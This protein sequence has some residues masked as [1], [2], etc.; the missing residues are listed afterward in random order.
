MKSEVFRELERFFEKENMRSAVIYLIAY[1]DKIC[2]A[3]HVDGLRA[4]FKRIVLSFY[5]LKKAVE[6]WIQRLSCF[7]ILIFVKCGD[8]NKIYLVLIAKTRDN[9]EAYVTIRELKRIDLTV[10]FLELYRK[11]KILDHTLR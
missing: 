5:Q 6:F 2:Y 11:N 9:N 10:K 4:F 7:E 1:R 3:K 8:G